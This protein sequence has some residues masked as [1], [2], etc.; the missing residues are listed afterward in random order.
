MKCCNNNCRQG[1]DCPN[2]SKPNL[3]SLGFWVYVI[4]CTAYI[5]AVVAAYLTYYLS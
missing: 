3:W 2:K 4:G 5:A 1:R